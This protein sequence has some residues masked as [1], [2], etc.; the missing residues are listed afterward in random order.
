MADVEL[1]STDSAQTEQA[2]NH[3]PPEEELVPNREAELEGL[4]AQKDEELKFADARVTEL[5]QT[6]ASLKSEVTTLKE[7]I[8]QSDQKL[9]EVTDALSQAVA[10]YK[11]RVIESNPEVPVDLIAGESIEAVDKSLEN[12]RA[13]I[14][15]VREGL[16]AEIKMAR[17]PAGAPLRAPL[18]LSALSPREKIQYAIGGFSS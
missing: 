10:S 18:D 9:A 2:A 11:A 7:S 5:E 4:L 15:K 14:S 8:L 17:I 13:I 1:N 6:A 3:N 12:A 16:E